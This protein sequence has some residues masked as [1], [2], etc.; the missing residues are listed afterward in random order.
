MSQC[1]HFSTNAALTIAAATFDRNSRPRYDGSY[2]RELSTLFGGAPAKPVEAKTGMIRRPAV[3]AAAAA[4]A[5]A[6]HTTHPSHTP[7]PRRRAVAEDG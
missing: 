5:V 7:H 2:G 4:A 3:E 1:S 6:T